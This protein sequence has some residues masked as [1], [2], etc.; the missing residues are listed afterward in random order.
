LDTV[1]A[2]TALP[3]SLSRIAWPLAA[4]FVLVGA[5]DTI[6]KEEPKVESRDLVKEE[7]DAR[8]EYLVR[9]GF[10]P[11]D[12]TCKDVEREDQGL[13]QALGGSV[14]GTVDF[15]PEAAADWI[16][17]LRNLSCLATDEVAQELADA[18]FAV[19]GGQVEAGGECFAD[20]ECVEGHICDRNACPADRLC[21]TGSCVEFRIL[22]EQ[23]ACQLP[24]DGVL[25]TSRCSSEFWC[26]PPD[27]DP[28]NPPE[29]P[30]AEGVCTAR[31]DNGQPC[32][33]NGECMDGL[34]CDTQDTQTCFKLSPHDAECNP[35]LATNPCLEVNDACDPG[36]S[37]CQIAPGPGEACPQGRC[38]G[39]ALCSGQGDPENPATCI[40]LLNRGEACDGS[41]PCLGDLVCRDGLCSDLTTSLVCVEG[42]PPPEPMMDGG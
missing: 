16:D 40:A 13:V 17:T 36:S 39:W 38:A 24:Q 37:S 2:V 12:G 22:G 3:L 41:L 35:M 32:N 15:N 1:D 21:C 5:C 7:L 14:F 26:R 6:G 8:C 20:D 25:I 28:E 23:A 42:E 19:F 11:D 18:R 34:R 29:M 33:A 9:C 31:V 4:A 27:V 30:P 10:M